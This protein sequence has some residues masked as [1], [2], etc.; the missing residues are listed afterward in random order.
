MEIDTRSQQQWHH[1]LFVTR[2][3]RWDVLVAYAQP[4]KLRTG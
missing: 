2:Y 1:R 3:A 4:R